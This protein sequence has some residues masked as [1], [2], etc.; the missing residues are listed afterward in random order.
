MNSDIV[1]FSCQMRKKLVVILF[2]HHIYRAAGNNFRD[3]YDDMYHLD[4]Y[5]H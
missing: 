4:Y 1:S 3:Q 2:L 5:V